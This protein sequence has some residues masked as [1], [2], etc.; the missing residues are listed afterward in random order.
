[1]RPAVGR[2]RSA[3][4]S[5]LVVSLDRG[6]TLF[7][8]NAAAPLAPASNLKLLTTAAAIQRLGPDFRYQ[9]FLLASGGIGQGELHGDLI[10]YG[11]GDPGLSGRFHPGGS[12][13]FQA[14]ADSLL[15][16]GI[17]VVRGDVVGD[18]SYFSGPLIAQG[19]NCLLYTSPSPRD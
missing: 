9:T 6:D 7:A 4:W 18:G 13:V 14:F 11:T 17:R 16:A 1:M 8:L 3:Q 10:L 15:A 12:A 2:W 5:I 19:W